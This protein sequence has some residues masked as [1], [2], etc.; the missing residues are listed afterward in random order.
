MA[1]KPT[2]TLKNRTN[3]D[4]PDHPI[5]RGIPFPAGTV[6]EDTH[7]SMLDDKGEAV[8][9]ATRAL[10]T[11]KDGSVQWML[12]DFL[13]SMVPRAADVTYSVAVG[14]I[15]AAPGNPVV[16]K[17]SNDAI[18]LDNGITTL[19]VRKSGGALI[20]Q[21]TVHGRPV[22]ASGSQSDIVLTAEGQKLFRASADPNRRVVIENANPVR[23]TLKV[24]GTHVAGDDATLLDYEVRLRLWANN[25]YIE[26]DHTFINR[27]ENPAGITIRGLRMDLDS[28]LGRDVT[29]IVR[30]V[31]HGE[32]P[33]PRLAEICENVDHVTTTNDDFDN[34]T[35]RSNH[36]GTTM[37]RNL[38]SLE[39]GDV[40]YSHYNSPFFQTT[41]RGEMRVGGYRTVFPH[42]GVT[43]G[44]T[45]LTTVILK[46]AHMHPKGISVDRN[47]ISYHIWPEWAKTLLINQGQSRTH[48]IRLDGRAGRMPNDWVD[49][50]YLQWGGPGVGSSAVEGDP[51]GLV[52]DHTYLAKCEV[53]EQQHVLP[54]MPDR[55][56]RLERLIRCTGN[57]PGNGIF[58]YGDGGGNNEDDRHV[59]WTACDYLRTG[60][61]KL[62]DLLKATAV[63]Y[64]ETDH[65]R[66]SQNPLRHGALMPHSQNHVEGPHYPSHQWVEGLIAYYCLSGN[67]RVK[68]AVLMCGENI[69]QWVDRAMHHI[70]CD[71]RETGIPC[72]NLALLYRFTHEEKYLKTARRIIEE[73]MIKKIDETGGILE[74]HPHGTNFGKPTAYG[75]YASWDAMLRYLEDDP[76]PKVKEYM[77]KEFELSLKGVVYAGTDDGRA[78]NFYAVWGA[79]RMTGDDSW[80]ERMKPG[81]SILLKLGGHQVRR[82][83]FLKL[84]HERGM[85][86]DDTVG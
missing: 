21:L 13:T 62:Y 27:E 4:H 36:L 72:M 48:E 6:S 86:N 69:L 24:T 3:L 19:V 53:L 77:L 43:D 78:H 57:L 68:E 8:P 59:W 26:I 32:H 64:A 28:S 42:I 46:S 66:Y 52:Y 33:F 7:L 31:R 67:E 61:S 76:D 84:L 35:E 5:S 65:I 25:S 40:Y 71:G 70:T 75:S 11:W 54:F 82:L 2:I 12:V 85:I 16:L 51:I 49:Q 29:T 55:Y 22:I 44:D 39:K 60:N 17:E 10:T 14:Q 47:I 81:I 1:V 9:C 79:H 58:N 45:T 38:S 30:Q 34:Y 37:I 18:M 56:P 50:A 73:G 63:H 83:H 41:F 74:S 15:P 80:I 20:D 23:A